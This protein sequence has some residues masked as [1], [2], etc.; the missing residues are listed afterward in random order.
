MRRQTRIKEQ[1]QSVKGLKSKGL[2]DNHMGMRYY[3]YQF[4]IP[5]LSL[6]GERSEIQQNKQVQQ[7]FL[8][9]PPTPLS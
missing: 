5:V 7:V 6:R 2:L 3:Q 8:T 9:S 1:V 4:P